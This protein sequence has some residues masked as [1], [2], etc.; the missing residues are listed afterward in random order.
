MRPAGHLPARIER[1]DQLVVAERPEEVVLQVVGARP[2]QLDRPTGR[3][4]DE[5]RFR[6]EVVGEPPAE[7][8]A[9]TRHLHA[10][11]G[12]RDAGH[13]V[14]GARGAARLL[15]GRNHA[16]AVRHHV[17]EGAGGLERRVTHE[18]NPVAGLHDL[19]GIAR[20]GVEVAVVAHH[21][22]G[23]REQRRALRIE[24]CARLGRKGAAR[25]LDLEG[26]AALQRG[27]GVVGDHR[28]PGRQVGRDRLARLRA[29]HH[30][31]RTHAWHGTRRGVVEARD[32]A[33]KIRATQHH[34]DARLG[35]LDV[36]AVA[37][38]AGDDVR[39]VHYAPRLADHAVLGRL[40]ERHGLG[41]ERKLRGRSCER[42]VRQPPPVRVK[43]MRRCG[44]D[45]FHCNA[46]LRRGG[47]PQQPA[48]LGAELPEFRPAVGDARAAA[49][50]LGSEAPARL[51][52]AKVDHHRHLLD[53]DQRPVGIQLFGEDHGQ[54][55][56]DA[57]PDLGARRA[58]HDAVV[59]LD[60]DQDAERVL[61]WRRRRFGR[62]PECGRE[63]QRA[64]SG[65][66]S[67]QEEPAR[68][69]GRERVHALSCI[70][71]A[72]RAMAR[73]MRT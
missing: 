69:H 36:D 20:R 70:S 7:A 2:H 67:L 3:L 5:C 42:R 53:R 30:D 17:H 59:R 40:L 72:A 33:V 37:R 68:D 52:A 9:R 63:H 43:R 14:H 56:L 18:R 44:L 24:R 32:A 10:D 62:L 41:G 11:R 38:A 27:P 48:G 60:A 58:D 39:G 26:V 47:M 45:R 1:R 66:R 25:P 8:A 73:R 35:L 6:D 54:R 46:P 15:Q 13:R 16:R 21:L 55:S 57:L 4:R 23:R 22:A 28:H 34:R 61:C 65:Y 31:H 29:R 51:G 50:A 64:R 19:G 71:R 12:A 49:R